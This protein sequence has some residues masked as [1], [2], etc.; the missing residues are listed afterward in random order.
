MF[1]WHD[2]GDREFGRWTRP[3]QNPTLW[4][5]RARRFVKDLVMQVKQEQR[6]AYKEEIEERLN[7]YYGHQ[8]E[9]VKT[10][11]RKRFPATYSL[12]KE[13]LINETRRFIKSMSKVYHRPP[14]R[15]LWSPMRGERV[16]DPLVVNAFHTLLRRSKY[17]RQ[18]KKCNE[19]TNLCWTTFQHYWY[20]DA[21]QRVEVSII[22]P[23]RLD[24][25]QS[26]NDPLNLQ[27]DDVA[28]VI[29]RPNPTD[30]VWQ[31]NQLRYTWWDKFEV[32]E[33]DSDGRLLRWAPNPYG[34]LPFTVVHAEEPDD[35]LYHRGG[36]DLTNCN[37]AINTLITDL[38]HSISN[39]AYGQPI[40][41]GVDP[42][43]LQGQVW[44]PDSVITLSH[45][46]S[47]LTFESPNANIMA[48]LKAIEMYRVMFGQ[49][50]GLPASDNALN[51]VAQ[52]ALS[53]VVELGTMREWRQDQIA[54]YRDFEVDEAW[55]MIVRINN[56]HG[57][58]IFD[59]RLELR[60][61]HAPL[62]QPVDPLHETERDERLIT[63]NL[64]S[65]A[66]TIMR[67]YQCDEDDAQLILEYFQ[68]TNAPLE[69]PAEQPTPT[70][71]EEAQSTDNTQRGQM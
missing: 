2:G 1:Q 41:K 22:P 18:L 12:M 50:R 3:V 23:S 70:E 46:E 35:E 5:K 39:Q 16:T 49:S 71:V 57:R 51:P 65:Q 67:E 19:L 60:V 25:L 29:E 61:I 68:G 32:Q 13:R 40:A 14:L 69:P 10:A 6:A 26:L 53:R 36:D 45:A 24:V 11:L 8:V 59:E 38:V 30:T 4:G 58:E 33:F 64:A 37:D 55:P 28:V 34:L 17:N 48:M 66:S 47:S 9:I 56:V 52:S 54:I 44:G 27:A 20:N 31:A 43:E 21:R 42:D 15:F 7:Y 63:A 62:R